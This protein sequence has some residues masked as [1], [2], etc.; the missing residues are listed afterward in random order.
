MGHLLTMKR[1][2]NKR[3]N[4]QRNGNRSSYGPTSTPSQVITFG[5]RIDNRANVV[6]RS[7]YTDLVISKGTL[8]IHGMSFLL[9]G[10]YIDSSFFTWTSGA[11][12]LSALYD[13]YRFDRVT[14]TAM[15]NANSGTVA[16]TI[17]TL[18]F[19]FY[20]VDLNDATTTGIG[21]ITQMST[22]ECV[23]AGNNTNNA[24]FIKTFTP[25]AQLQAYAGVSTAYAEA[26]L[27]TWFNSSSLPIHYGLKWASDATAQTATT[28]TSGYVRIFVKAFFSA[29][30]P[31]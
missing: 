30:Q 10:F 27:G 12:D 21:D 13:F 25:R 7:G 2:A 20:A 8:G 4:K 26:P 19:F 5:N 3:R 1:N 22:C 28:G 29:K 16:G 6:V 9:T 18:P 24:L 11:T 17:D 14:V 23:M 31:K 15:F